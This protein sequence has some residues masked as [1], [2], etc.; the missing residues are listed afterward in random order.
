M[1]DITYWTP[2]NLRR[3][4]QT[5]LSRSQCLKDVAEAVLRHICS[6]VKD[7]CNLYKYDAE[8]WNCL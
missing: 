3:T 5:R 1:P 6:D 2:Q 8:Y 7:I 4:V